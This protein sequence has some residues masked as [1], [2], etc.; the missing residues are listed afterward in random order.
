MKNSGTF[1]GQIQIAIFYENI[2]IFHVTQRFGRAKIDFWVFLMLKLIFATAQG[3][4]S[5]NFL[6]C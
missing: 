1:N 6:T 2:I 3:G 4:D 5:Q